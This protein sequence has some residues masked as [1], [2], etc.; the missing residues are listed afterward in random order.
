MPAIASGRTSGSLSTDLYYLHELIGALDRRLPQSERADS[1][2]IAR[3][4]AA[5]RARAVERLVELEAALASAASL[6]QPA[7]DLR[8]AC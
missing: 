5:L 8:R 6:G 2:R 1:A 3:E 4:C 7:A